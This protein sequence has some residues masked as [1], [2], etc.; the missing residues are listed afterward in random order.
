MAELKIRVN[1]CAAERKAGNVKKADFAT[2][3]STDRSVKDRNNEL[4]KV[5]MIKFPGWEKSKE[6]PQKIVLTPD[7][8]QRIHQLMAPL[9]NC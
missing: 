5:G 9:N 8:L 7:Q 1:L 2:F 3:S 6:P 4:I